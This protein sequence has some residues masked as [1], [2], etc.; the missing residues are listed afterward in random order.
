[1]SAIRDPAYITNAGRTMITAGGDISYTKA[2]L[3]GQDISHL[4]KAQI[5]ALTTIGNPLLEVKVGIS[6]KKN[7]DNRTTVV[8]QSTFQN[9]NLKSDLPY[10]AVGFFAKKGND[11]EKLVLV[12]VA[13]AGAYLSAT[14]PDGVA[15][16]ALDLKVAITIG[17]AANV[18]AVVDPSGS[19][20]PAT[21][22]GAITKA[23]QDLTALIDTKADKQTVDDEISKIDFTPYAKTAD[24]DQKLEAYDKINDV[25][26][27]I[28]KVTDLA[29]SKVDATY[30][31]S[32]DELDKKLL[33]LSTDT[34]GKIDAA[35][36][37][38]MI[39]GKANTNDVYNKKEVDDA[40]NLRDQK[41]DTKA[42]KSTTYTKLDIDK[43]LKSIDFGKIAFRKQYTADNNGTTSYK[44][45]SAKKQ[46]DGTWLIDLSNED[47]T[48]ANARDALSKAE[49]NEGGINNLNS[50]FDK[51]SGNQAVKNAD[52]NAITTSGTYFIDSPGNNFPIDHWGVL[53]V[54]QANEDGNIRLEQT[55]YPDDNSSPWFRTKITDT[56]KPWYQVA[57]KEDINN[58]N[59]KIDSNDKATITMGY[60]WSEG[61]PT[62]ETRTLQNAWL[63][64]Q[65]VLKG[66]V[67]RMSDLQN[68]INDRATNSK[69]NV[70]APL[71]RR[72][73]S[74]NTWQDILGV[75]NTK[76]NQVLVSVRDEAGGNT[77]GNFS[78]AVAFG[79]SDTKGVLN[80][81]YS[82]HI[83]RI[84][85]GNGNRPLWHEDIAWK[86]DIQNLLNMLNQQSQQIQLLTT[87]LNNAKNEIDYIKQN[88]VE[89]KRF[90]S[91]Q[92]D[93]AKAWES[94]NSQRIAFI[95]D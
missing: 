68:Q 93:Q 82:N 61:R 66:A 64:D 87:Q 6:V 78:S 14:R 30:S 42:D 24:I 63:V 12:A 4:E 48:A 79:G 83:A 26:D 40:F 62:N 80:V 22:S 91:N 58:L 1:M 39:N 7:T 75:A 52:A 72:I 57:S 71:F 38:D 15:T 86:S 43:A 85:G 3:Y 69:V 46:T 56:W 35:Q 23:T 70:D 50:R 33:A 49:S 92:E 11:E 10:T 5:E 44:T 36:V 27:K 84:I 16:D 73:T 59:S 88:Y 25:D 21:L 77:I 51:Y 76:G 47:W 41:I 94:Q 54:H 89:G 37:A 17:D 74:S 29:N 95:S 20:T 53:V 31:Y 28:K 13:N 32:K 65:N 90:A 67:D 19:V 18:T 9:S 2:I 34:N 81:A 60:D 55:F 45:W 8:L